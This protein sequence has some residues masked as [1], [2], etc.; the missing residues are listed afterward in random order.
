[1]DIK[2]ED[3]KKLRSKTGAG[4]ADCRRALEKTKGDFKKAEEL[5]K[6]WGVDK[7]AQKSDRAVGAGLVE[8]YIHAG[9][10][11]GALIEINCETD[12][13]TKTDEFKNLAHE[14]AMQ[15]AAMDPKD[16]EE[17]LRQEYIRDSSKKID[18]LVKEV[19][20]KVGE[21]IIVKRFI[22]FELGG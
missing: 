16:V 4:I 3:I 22:R 9:G 7:A 10:R 15:V 19:I 21:N 11:V 20:T 1:M 5:L 2:I 6:S 18:D 17:L 8:T 12:F 14:V 13:V